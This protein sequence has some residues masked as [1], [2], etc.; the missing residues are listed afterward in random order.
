MAESWLKRCLK[1]NKPSERLRALLILLL[2]SIFSLNSHANEAM[3]MNQTDQVAP[4]PLT[5]TT[6]TTT[7]TTSESNAISQVI[8]KEP[9]KNATG[10]EESATI[11]RSFYT[12][13]VNS[14]D[15][16]QLASEP[17]PNYVSRSAPEDRKLAGL[18]KRDL[19][20]RRLRNERLESVLRASSHLLNQKQNRNQTQEPLARL[21]QPK[22]SSRSRQFL[23]QIKS[24]RKRLRLLKEGVPEKIKAEQQQVVV[25]KEGGNQN[26]TQ[27]ASAQHKNWV[28]L[29]EIEPTTEGQSVGSEELISVESAPSVR[30]SAG[31]RQQVAAAAGKPDDGSREARFSLEKQSESQSTS[32]ERPGPNG[33]KSTTVIEHGKRRAKIINSR[34]P[35][36]VLPPKL[37]RRII[38]KFIRNGGDPSNIV[39]SDSTITTT[40]Q[41]K[42]KTI[43]TVY[44]IVPNSGP[45]VPGRQ[46]GDFEHGSEPF[47]PAGK[48]SLDGSLGQDLNGIELGLVRGGLRR[49]DDDDGHPKK[50]NNNSGEGRN[51]KLKKIM[52][53]RIEVPQNEVEVAGKP[54]MSVHPAGNVE[55]EMGEFYKGPHETIFGLGERPHEFNREQKRDIMK[56]DEV[57]GR[58][59]DHIYR[60]RNDH[61]DKRP[62]SAFHGAQQQQQQHHPKMLLGITGNPGVSLS[63]SMSTSLDWFK[64]D[65][66]HHQEQ[67]EG[68]KEE[69]E[70]EEERGREEHSGKHD[71][72]QQKMHKL[73]KSSAETPAV[74]VTRKGDENNDVTEQTSDQDT[75]SADK[76]DDNAGG[77][78]GG[79]SGQFKLKANKHK[80]DKRQEAEPRSSNGDRKL[81]ANA[82]PE[83]KRRQSE[84]KRDSLDELKRTISADDNNNN[85]HNSGS[86]GES[87]TPSSPKAGNATD[88]LKKQDTRPQVKQPTEGAINQTKR[89]TTTTKS[90]IKAFSESSDS[91][92]EA[93]SVS[94][95]EPSGRNSETTQSK[96]GEDGTIEAPVASTTTQAPRVAP[97]ARLVAAKLPQTAQQTINSSSRAPKSTNGGGGKTHNIMM[98]IDF[99]PPD[100][101]SSPGVQYVE[102]ATTKLSK[103]NQMGGSR[104]RV[105]FNSIADKLQDNQWRPIEDSRPREQESSKPRPTGGQHHPT[106]SV[107]IFNNN[108]TRGPQ[109]GSKQ[110]FR[111]IIGPMEANHVEQQVGQGLMLNYDEPDG[112][113]MNEQS[114]EKE[115]GL[116]FDSAASSHQR[117][118]N[119]VGQSGQRQVQGGS[120][121]LVGF[122]GQQPMRLATR[123]VGSFGAPMKIGPTGARDEESPPIFFATGTEA[124]TAQNSQR[125]N[126]FAASN[127]I[128]KALP[129]TEILPGESPET[130]QLVQQI[131]DELSKPRSDFV[132]HE[133]LASAASSSQSRWTTESKDLLGDVGSPLEATATQLIIPNVLDEDEDEAVIVGESLADLQQ[134]EHSMI[135]GTGSFNASLPIR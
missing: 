22:L 17:Q 83:P 39:V 117:S 79:P 67:E 82:R 87:V 44:K 120:N 73:D 34:D 31:S 13:E 21:E 114:R 113:L 92:E 93:D 54:P 24:K 65:D 14:T 26:L 101:L 99:G 94:S 4:P 115:Y 85:S 129:V 57:A 1:P 25:A 111:Q 20:T 77:S 12:I 43:T 5:T 80:S 27:A 95:S 47:L 63:N 32:E 127:T 64:K 90:P 62:V 38:E 112:L 51:R 76:A 105:W 132:S 48:V 7:S 107:Q 35:S 98:L 81:P 72:G 123:F 135:N 108:P 116:I 104:P 126:E 36:N 69:E 15:L 3:K 42:R 28:I 30:S 68:E 124:T 56:F 10:G 45:P 84:K 133:S 71:G 97:T 9:A 18:N 55:E 23:K 49:D 6:T 19:Q 89:R 91:S 29:N 50:K 134:L 102:P 59:Q 37:R 125:F 74:S 2:M 46:K 75:Q 11:T 53:T 86:G 16:P 121:Q 41:S 130:N 58:G 52:V 109:M 128:Q 103:T 110:E 131:I 88:K 78:R 122:S 118:P 61:D 106:V 119:V 66:G 96:S 60:D 100:E 40:S 70:E 8:R 33:S